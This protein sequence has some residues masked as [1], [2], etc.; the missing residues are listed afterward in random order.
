MNE[1]SWSDLRAKIGVKEANNELDLRIGRICSLLKQLEAVLGENSLHHRIHEER[2]LW[3]PAIDQ[4]ER[5]VLHLA[6]KDGH[7]KLVRCLVFSGGL[8][9]AK[10]GI[11]QTPLT[12]ALHHGQ[13]VIAMFL[14]NNGATVNDDDY[15][16]TPSPKEIASALERDDIIQIIEEKTR[17]EDIVIQNLFSQ[18]SINR[19]G[20]NNDNDFEMRSDENLGRILNINVGDQKNTANIQGC[21]NRCPDVYSCHTPGGGDFHNRGYI[22][23]CIARVAGHGGLWHVLENVMKR[24]TVNKNSFKDKFKDNNYNNNEEALLD[25][26]DGVS[27]AM[28]KAFQESNDFPKQNELEECYRTTGSHNDILLKTFSVWKEKMSKDAQF[29]YQSKIVNELMP[30]SR[31]YKESIRHGNGIA[32]EGVWMKCPPLYAALGKTNYRDE[33]LTMVVNSIAKWPLAYRKMYQQNRTVNLSGKRGKNIAGD[34][35][36]EGHLVKPVKE[37]ASSQT[38][39]NVLE[40]LS[41]SSGLLEINKSMYRSRDAFDVHTTK[42][43]YTP[44]SLYDQLKVSQ[45]ALKEQWFADKSRKEPKA[46]SWSGH[47]CKDDEHVPK[48]YLNVLEIGQKKLSEEFVGFLNRKFPNDLS[49]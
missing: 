16:T 2:E 33:S 1:L 44:P 34:E 11:G 12:L 17:E 32:I 23:E 42:K 18:L 22:N 27:I 47:T 19:E 24:P 8:I 4:F 5:T 46:Y 13:F 3:L 40:L 39:F 36:V 7:V 45:F 29:E 43:H 38:S 49:I 14:I 6:A 31:W 26:D 48:Q 15:L 35:W 20:S 10:D 28:L 21:V 37:Y 9:N 41:C 30:L 25:F